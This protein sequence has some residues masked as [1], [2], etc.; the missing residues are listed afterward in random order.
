MHLVFL[1]LRHKR[2]RLFQRAV[3]AFAEDP[4]RGLAK[5]GW[6]MFNSKKESWIEIAKGNVPRATF[7]KPERYDGGCGDVVLGALSVL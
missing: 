1:H 7:V 6:P 2:I 5:M 3:A 4:K